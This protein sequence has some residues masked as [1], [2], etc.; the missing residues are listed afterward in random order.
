MRKLIFLAI[1]IVCVATVFPFW[2]LVFEH[3]LRGYDNQSILQTI[4]DEIVLEPK[5]KK[6]KTARKK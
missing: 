1:L 2:L 6:V 3:M 4:F 5:P